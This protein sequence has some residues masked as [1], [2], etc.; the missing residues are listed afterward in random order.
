M[1]NSAEHLLQRQSLEKS[2]ATLRERVEKLRGE[3]ADLKKKR[4]KSEKDTHEFVA[5][6][7]KEMEK[8]DEMIAQLN[9]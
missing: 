4:A 9:T 7:Q 6:F 1:M 2:C 8:K 3:N 5:Y